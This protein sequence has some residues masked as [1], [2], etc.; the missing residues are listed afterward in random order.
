VPPRAIVEL[1][2]LLGR[3]NESCGRENS[4]RIVMIFDADGLAILIRAFAGSAP[5]RAM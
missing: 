4:R 5:V 2:Y 3:L 1:G